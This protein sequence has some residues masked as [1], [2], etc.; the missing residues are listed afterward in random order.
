MDL[1]FFRVWFKIWYILLDPSKYWITEE[2]ILIKLAV[3]LFI[4][5]GGCF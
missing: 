2:K 1:I 3:Q 4:G 5:E